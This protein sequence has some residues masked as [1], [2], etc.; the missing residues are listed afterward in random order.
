M[1]VKQDDNNYVLEISIYVVERKNWAVA[2]NITKRVG[3]DG[4]HKCQRMYKTLWGFEHGQSQDLQKKV[5]EYFK[6]GKQEERQKEW[7]EQRK[8]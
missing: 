7:H 3:G 5:K 8:R 4:T 6:R 1:V 2:N